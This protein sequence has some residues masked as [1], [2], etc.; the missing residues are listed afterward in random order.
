MVYKII[1][2]LVLDCCK[3]Y[4]FQFSGRTILLSTHHMDEAEI[5]G[6]RIG[7]ISN[8]Q[9]KCCGSPLFLKSTFGDGY[10]LSLVKKPTDL[11]VHSTGTV[12]LKG[13]HVHNIRKKSTSRAYVHSVN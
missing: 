3:I 8:G 1:M 10:H 11:D 5:L 9:L 12:S 2:I 7:I 4:I 6:D 13:L